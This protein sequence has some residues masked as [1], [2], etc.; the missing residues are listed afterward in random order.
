MKDSHPNRACLMPISHRAQFVQIARQ[1]RHAVR[2][3]ELNGDRTQ[4]FLGRRSGA[5]PPLVKESFNSEGQKGNLGA[6]RELADV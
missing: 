5:A 6:S 4:I 3:S 2:S 1:R